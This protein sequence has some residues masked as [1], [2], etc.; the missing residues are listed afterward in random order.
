M[1]ELAALRACCSARGAVLTVGETVRFLRDGG[2]VRLFHEG[3][4]LRFQIDAKIARA[5]GLRVHAQL[6]S[7]AAD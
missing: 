5:A 1:P 4:R 7:L 6:L 3:G 2:M